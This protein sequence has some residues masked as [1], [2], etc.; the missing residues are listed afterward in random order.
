MSHDD[1]LRARLDTRENHGS[2][3]AVGAQRSSD[4]RSHGE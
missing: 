3:V 1:D 2:I 4:A